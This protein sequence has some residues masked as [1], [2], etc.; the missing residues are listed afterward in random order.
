QGA[1][2]Y[3]PRRRLSHRRGQAGVI[4]FR[5]IFARIIILHVIAVVVTAIVMPLVLS[6]LVTSAA[7]DLHDQAM[8]EQAEQVARHLDVRPDGHWVLD[9]PPGLQDLYSTAYG[10]YAYAVL[11]A[12]GGVL[13]SSLKDRSPIFERDPRS[14]NHPFM[15]TRTGDATMSG[16]SIEREVAGRKVWVQV[17]E[18]LAHRDVIIDD[19]VA[20]FFRRA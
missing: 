18:D 1:D 10:R 13:F 8:R 2:P 9:L 17:G 16:V 5:S 7:N 20:E 19:V 12:N 15:T 3:H 6:W 4:P 11:D 14:P